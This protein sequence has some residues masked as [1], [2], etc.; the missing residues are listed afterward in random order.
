MRVKK[1]EKKKETRGRKKISIDW[2][3][4][5]KLASYMCTAK[6]IGYILGVAADTL[7]YRCKTEQSC[8]LEDFLAKNQSTSLASLRVQQF[9]AAKKGSIQMM[10]WLGKQYLGQRDQIS[11]NIDQTTTYTELQSMSDKEIK[12]RIKG[13]EKKLRANAKK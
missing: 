12:N 6:E 3:K 4:A 8:N 2:E 13:I 7:N 11:Q 1:P 5:A 9:A 10:I